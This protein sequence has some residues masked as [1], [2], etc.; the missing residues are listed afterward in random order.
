MGGERVGTCIGRAG[1]V[2]AMGLIQPG[3]ELGL[4]ARIVGP[5]L[6]ARHGL[7]DPAGLEIGPRD[8]QDIGAG[9][10]PEVTGIAHAALASSRR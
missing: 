2:T 9:A 3:A 4:A 8:R 6:Q 7:F 5:G 1:C 10:T